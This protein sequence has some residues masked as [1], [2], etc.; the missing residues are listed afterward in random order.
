MD[1]C[2]AAATGSQPTMM[3]A[4]YVIGERVIGVDATDVAHVDAEVGF[5]LSLLHTHAAVQVQIAMAFSLEFLLAVLM[6][7][8]ISVM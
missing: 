8:S 7:F 6:I 1:A 2:Y 5:G 3:H 4:T